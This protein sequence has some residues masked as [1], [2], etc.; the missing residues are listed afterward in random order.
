MVNGNDRGKTVYT[1][2]PLRPD[3]LKESD[4]SLLLLPHVLPCIYI[5]GGTTGAVSLNELIFSIL[6]KLL[7]QFVV[8]HQTGNLSYIT[9]EKI[10]SHLPNDMKQRYFPKSYFSSAETSWI[11]HHVRFVVSRSGANIVWELGAIGIPAIFVPLPWSHSF[12]QQRN[13]QWLGEKGAAMILDQNHITSENLMSSIQT[14][15]KEYGTY[16]RHA[17]AFSRDI[18]R[19]GAERL[20]RE[21]I[22]VIS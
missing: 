17:D 22:S 16:K 1:G 9:A 12:E 8:I 13:A 6:P 11:F 18:P 21:V 19:D 4:I 7:D 3:V 5:T 20:L 15:Y 14:M 10:A 2:L